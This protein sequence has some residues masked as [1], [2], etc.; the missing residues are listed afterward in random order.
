MSIRDEILEA[1]RRHATEHGTHELPMPPARRFVVV[2]CMD[3]RIDP[4]RILG[5]A[6]GDA[7]VLRNAG[8]IVNEDVLRSLVIS[9]WLQDTQEVLVIGH[10]GCGMTGF[11]NERSARGSAEETGADASGIDFEPFA[12]LEESVRASVARIPESPFLPGV[13]ASGW[14]YD[15]GTGALREVAVARPA[16]RVRVRAEVRVAAA[17]VGDVRVDLGRPEVGVAEHLLDAA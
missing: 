16:L 4:A 9:H 8:A 11:T 6:E 5:L 14:V 7:H 10:T 3:A 13:A 2:T 17:L 15:V 12:D 1:N